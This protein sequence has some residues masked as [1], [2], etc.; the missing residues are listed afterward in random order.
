[1]RTS[2]HPLVLTLLAFLLV[3][4][5]LHPAMAGD[6]DIES[7]GYQGDPLPP[8]LDAV[9]SRGIAYLVKT[10]NNAGYWPDQRGMEPAVVGLAIVAMLAQ[11]GDPNHGPLAQPIRRALNFIQSQMNAQ[12]GYI[13]SSM[14]NHGFATLALAESYGAVDDERLGPALKRAVDLILAAQAGNP[15]GGWRYGPDAKDADMTVSGCQMVALLAARNAG[16]AVPDAA[17]RRGLLF[18]AGCQS[19]D[20]GFGYVGPDGAAPVRGA[21]GTLVFALARQ[22][23]TAPFT[24]AAAYIQ[25]AGDDAGGHPFY[26]MYY[27]S[28]AFFHSNM[29]VWKVWNR[30]RLEQ[31]KNA[32]SADGAWHGNNGPVFSTSSALLALALNYRY[33][34]IYER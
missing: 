2:C 8:D 29:A 33:L 27:A 24:A 17:I 6:A 20:G 19:P 26:Y 21:I 25:R 28:Q 32:Q 31:L 5:G 15:S 18:M 9:Y 14:Y 11:G 12:T 13:G 30:T 7:S 4:G 10:Q 34:P 23:E 16:I 1:M 3:G 22:R